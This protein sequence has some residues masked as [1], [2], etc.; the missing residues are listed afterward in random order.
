MILVIGEKVYQR[1]YYRS[2]NGCKK[3]KLFSVFAVKNHLY[4]FI[5][6]GVGS[7]LLVLTVMGIPEPLCVERVTYSS[8][9]FF[10]YV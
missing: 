1:K 6:N 4:V 7:A 10:I 5:H 3:H 8:Y 9:A 2:R